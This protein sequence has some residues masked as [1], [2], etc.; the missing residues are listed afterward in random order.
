MWC[1]FPSCI[2][3]VF[4]RRSLRDQSEASQVKRAHALRLEFLEPKPK[5]RL[6]SARRSSGAPRRGLFYLIFVW[7][8]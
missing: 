2:V 3:G 1:Y 4:P 7:S 8:R 6:L 5:E